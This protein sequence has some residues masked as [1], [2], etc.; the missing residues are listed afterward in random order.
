M[1][2]TQTSRKLGIPEVV[3]ET[4][5]GQMSSCWASLVSVERMKSPYPERRRSAAL[6]AYHKLTNLGDVL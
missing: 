2:L 3:T 4:I 5:T 6:R 1:L